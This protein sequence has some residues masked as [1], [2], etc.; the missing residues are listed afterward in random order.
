MEKNEKGEIINDNTEKIIMDF[1]KSIKYFLDGGFQ[2]L[3]MMDINEEKLKKEN[4]DIIELLS[5]VYENDLE[6]KKFDIP[7]I[8]INKEEKSYESLKLDDV[9]SNKINNSK[10][11][12]TYMKKMFNIKNEVEEE[13]NGL[14]SLLSILNYKTDNYIISND[15]FIKM[16]FVAYRILADIPVIIMGEPSCGKKD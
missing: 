14:K 13:K 15:I 6:N 10:D 7:L 12:L 1:A 5:K 4:K 16:I 11:Y 2:N 3:I 8:F 9:I